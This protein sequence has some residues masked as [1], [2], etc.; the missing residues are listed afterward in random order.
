[1]QK[2]E[3]TLQ[4]RLNE[5][6]LKVFPSDE[7]LETELRSIFQH[8][9]YYFP[10]FVSPTVV[11]TTSDVDYRNKIITELSNQRGGLSP[12]GIE[13][14]FGDKS[15]LRESGRTAALIGARR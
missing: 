1:M 12:M 3:D 7:K 2:I 11:T 6:V 10:Q 8:I 4:Q 9:K 15:A 14:A 5:E 13:R